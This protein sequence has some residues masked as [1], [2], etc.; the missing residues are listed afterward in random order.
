[1]KRKGLHP[2]YIVTCAF[3]LILLF[4]FLWSGTHNWIY[5]GKKYSKMY[6]FIIVLF[7]GIV[8]YWKT[9]MIYYMNVLYKKS[10]TT[11]QKER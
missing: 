11:Q 6:I 4:I 8:I 7:N 10:I 1:M 3:S 2:L 9:E 5:G